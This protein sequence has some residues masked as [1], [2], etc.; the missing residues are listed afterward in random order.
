MTDSWTERL[1]DYL[2][3]ELTPGERAAL[4]AHLAG[5]ATCRD[6]L[7][8]LGRVRSWAAGYEGSA[9][10]TD[11]WP[12]IRRALGGREPQADTVPL[13]AR[14]RRRTVR[15]GAPLAL[16]ASLVFATVSGVTWWV[17]RA[18]APART[19]PTADAMAV[20]AAASVTLHAAE[21]YGVAIGELERALV[22]RPERLDSTTVRVLREKLA[23][24]DA[25]IA[26]ALDALAQ[27][28]ASGY[29]ADHFAD[30]MRRKLSLLRNVASTASFES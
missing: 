5:C 17:A 14:G 1:S 19:A 25:A 29:L 18:T 12:G 21:S 27:D 16:A 7:A 15:L 2:D 6:D 28:P 26:E 23:S 22:D 3:D 30:L 8:R 20:R 10:R 9:P 24:I 13:A 4:D 11:P